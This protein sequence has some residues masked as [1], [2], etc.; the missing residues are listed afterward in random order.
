MVSGTAKCPSVEAKTASSKRKPVAGSA[1][2]C[3]A[4]QRGPNR[5]GIP[6]APWMIASATTPYVVPGHRDGDRSP[7]LAM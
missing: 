5:P 1:R 7:S 2:Q 4:G 6:S 3:R